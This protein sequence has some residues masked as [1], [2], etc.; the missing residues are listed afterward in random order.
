MQFSFSCCGFVDDHEIGCIGIL[1]ISSE[2]RGTNAV[3]HSTVW[4]P[5][6]PHACK[7]KV[8]VSP[9]TL[10]KPYRTVVSARRPSKICWGSH[11]LS[12]IFARKPKIWIGGIGPR[13]IPLRAVR[14]RQIHCCNYNVAI[15][16][17][18]EHLD[19]WSP[20]LLRVTIDVE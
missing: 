16:C 13:W 11:L 7:P 3:V 20:S 12:P 15:I 19:A 1:N 10:R 8:L 9:H 4:H 2:N 18:L 17:R 5:P 6:R 14:V